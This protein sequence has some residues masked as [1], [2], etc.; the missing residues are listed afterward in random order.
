MNVKAKLAAILIITAFLVALFPYV[1]SPSVVR[2][3]I[4]AASGTVW[5]T[6]SNNARFTMGTD[7]TFYRVQANTTHIWFDKSFTA[8]YYTRYCIYVTAPSNVNLTINTWFASTTGTASL[9]ITAPTGAQIKLGFYSPNLQSASVSGAIVSQTYTS[10]NQTLNFVAYRS[11]T[12][13]QTF[14]LSATANE[15]LEDNIT[16][17]NVAVAI[18]DYED[19]AGEKWVFS[20]ESY[21]TFRA[22]YWDGNGYSTLNTVKMAFNVGSIT[23]YDNGW[24]NT[25]Y[26]Q[27]A[28]EYALDSGDG[29]V[30]LKAG[31]ITA[32]DAN[33]LQVTFL[34]YFKNTVLDASDI[35][36]YLWC[37]DTRGASDGWEIIKADYF[38]IYNQGGHSTLV[39]SGDAGRSTGGDVFDLYANSG[40]SWAY[41]SVEYRNLVHV[42]L[43]PTVNIDN[44]SATTNFFLK[45]GMD[46]CVSGE[47]IS[48][49]LVK[50]GVQGT[51]VTG[52]A[53]S[54]DATAQWYYG[55]SGIKTDYCYMFPRQNTTT[56]TFR[57]WL[58]LWFNKVNSSSVQGGRVNAYEYPIKNAAHPWFVWLTGDDW[59][60]DDDKPKESD[61]FIMM[62]DVD[63]NTVYTQ[64]IQM[65]KLWFNVSVSVQADEGVTISNHDVFDLTFGGEP[66]FGIQTPVFDE[67]KVP[68]MP[69]GGFLGALTSWL[70]IVWKGLQDIFGPAI[71]GFWD[72]FVGFLDSVFTYF[73]WNNGFSQILSIISNF[74]GWV[75]TSLSLLLIILI[76]IFLFIV[77]AFTQMVSYFVQFFTSLT[78]FYNDL[79]WIWN[80]AY[81]YWGWIPEVIQQI[82]PLLFLFAALWILSPL[83]EQ[84]SLQRGFEGVKS[85]LELTVGWV[86]KGAMFLWRI[87]DFV[88][89]T[90][91][92]LIEE[93]PVVE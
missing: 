67:T 16:P 24:V 66:L 38:N 73:G 18:T 70:A 55:D 59:G 58:D 52:S 54:V 44:V 8:H 29:M 56:S 43:L 82:L 51:T 26:D 2:D 5:R 37:N 34:I 49:L 25:S 53:R 78:S 35:D 41:C 71:L 90:V 39:T 74:L 40:G 48:G 12:S 88:I 72:A 92:R 79:L 27:V 84:R 11:G 6:S 47:W 61:C 17:E 89:D 83:L 33:T 1:Y 75:S 3:N 50:I 65:V 42:K 13:S 20:E 32:L 81:P 7:L 9:T 85:R 22:Q 62:K 86:W 69:Q 63:G 76:E 91:Y 36:L 21:Y 30:N 19:V 28:G 80:Y 77:G 64:E 15:T 23:M 93:V 31:T 14:T 10:A 4:T 68:V 60:I 45:Y 46:F 87:V 57:Y